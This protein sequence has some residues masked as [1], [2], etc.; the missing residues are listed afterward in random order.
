[1][2]DTIQK[3]G[4]EVS[5]VIYDA[6]LPPRYFRF[7]KKFIRTFFVVVPVLFVVSLLALFLWGLGPRIMNQPRPRL[8]EVISPDDSHLAQLETEVKSLQQINKDLTDKLSALPASPAGGAEEP[9][10]MGIIRPY[11][12]QNFLSQNRV[13]LDQFEFVQNANDIALKF[14]IISSSPEIKVTGHVIVFMVTPTGVMAYPADANNGFSQGIKFSMGEPFSV[15]R[16]R[17]TS[18]DFITKLNSPTAKFVIYIF[19]R[20][21]DLLL[22]KETETFKTATKS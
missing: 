6:P 15:S 19:S 11:G 16:L 9:Y 21:G 8:P 17:P 14:Q 5:I 2:N 4:S 1:M 22:I 3:A 12:M 10:L 13:T 7:T 18:A 20:E